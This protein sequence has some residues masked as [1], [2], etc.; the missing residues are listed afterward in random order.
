MRVRT[1]SKSGL[2]ITEI[3]VYE[4]FESKFRGFESHRSFS[5]VFTR[6]Y[7]TLE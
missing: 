7:E 3:Y 2:E 5:A 1:D 4:E 6:V